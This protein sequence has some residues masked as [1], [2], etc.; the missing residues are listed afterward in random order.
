MW[1]RH[2]SGL[3]SRAAPPRHPSG[4]P[5]DGRAPQPPP[6]ATIVVGR[7]RWREGR[8]GRSPGSSCFRIVRG[9]SHT[10]VVSTLVLPSWVVPDVDS[11]RECERVSLR[12]LRLGP[13]AMTTRDGGVAAALVWLAAVE[14]AHGLALIQPHTSINEQ[15]GGGER[16]G[17]RTPLL[18][19]GC[20]RT[21]GLR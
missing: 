17:G 1:L 2:R 15:G 5:S 19:F 8:S 11:V 3:R 12:R 9:R 16:Q 13:R 21:H 10:R 14:R 6:T 7:L 20:S 4:R 18:R